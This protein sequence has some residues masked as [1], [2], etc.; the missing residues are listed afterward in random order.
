MTPKVDSL[1]IVSNTKP[2]PVVSKPENNSDIEVFENKNTKANI[3]E[4]DLSNQNN[5]KQIEE[6]SDN[7]KKWLIG[8]GII[9]GTLA[10][11]VASY[12]LFKKIN[13]KTFAKSPFSYKASL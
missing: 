9:L 3:D 6:K 5:N 12:F 8:A 4:I 7:K 10:V 11:G 13:A 1:N 2:L